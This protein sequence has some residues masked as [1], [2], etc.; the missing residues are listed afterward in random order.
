MALTLFGVNKGSFSCDSIRFIHLLPDQKNIQICI[1]SSTRL[2]T[3]SQI[4]MLQSVAYFHYNQF[5]G[6]MIFQH[7]C[8][9]YLF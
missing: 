1:A 2:E 9:C 6:S 8:L 4:Q 7:A 3:L 5:L